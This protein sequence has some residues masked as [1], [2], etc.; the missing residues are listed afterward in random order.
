MRPE[1]EKALDLLQEYRI[2]EPPVPVE[3]IAN[4]LGAMIIRNHFDGSESGF[5]YR[6]GPRVIIGI[7]SRTSR[8]RQRFSIAHEIGHL[9]L[10][11]NRLI[12]DHAV[13]IDWRDGVSSLG[14]NRQEIE[15][16]SF[17]ATLLMPPDMVISHVKEY[18][19]RISQ[20]GV[21]FPRDELIAGLARDFDVSSEAMGFRL[22]NLGVLAT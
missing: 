2:Y 18:A 10:H 19:S 12:V 3:D 14:T 16:N 8:K 4:S 11:N 15:A 5:T 1:E 13:R 6:N 9:V 7:N 20:P 21:G 17:G 22:I